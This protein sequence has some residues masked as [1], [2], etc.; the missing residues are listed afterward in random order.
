HPGLCERSN[1]AVDSVR[2]VARGRRIFAWSRGSISYSP[3]MPIWRRL[4]TLRHV[5][6][7][8]PVPETLEPTPRTR[9]VR[10]PH[11]GA[12]D[13]ETIDAILDEGFVCHLGFS[14]DGQPYVIP[15]MYA[16]VGDA[17]YFHGSA[18]SRML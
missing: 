16:R 10:E 5:F 11:R 1:M 6:H 7:E 14:V 15:T 12:Y 4:S 17:A 13:R 9:V 18:A 2:R 3:F 8:V